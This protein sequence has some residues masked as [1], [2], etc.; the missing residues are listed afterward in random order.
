APPRRRRPDRTGRPRP[1]RR[2][3]ARRAGLTRRVLPAVA[4]PRG[5]GRLTPTGRVSGE[6]NGRRRTSGPPETRWTMTETSTAT[7]TPAASQPVSRD[8]RLPKLGTVAAFA[9]SM[10]HGWDTP[11][12]TPNVSAG[13][14]TA[15][16]AHRERLS[17]AFPGTLLV[18]GGG[19]APVRSNDTNYDFR[20][21]SNFYWLT[22]C[23]AENA[24]LVLT[25]AGSGHDAT[26]FM[27]APAHP[28]DVAFFTD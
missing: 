24:V 17:A 2:R 21:D 16:A 14:A 9:E 27:P 18:V 7:D 8:P 12:R 3:P 23:S 11:D 6:D 19:A 22:A 10:K 5:L 15:A 4:A 13:A 20:P 1:R 26:V 28:G 25:P